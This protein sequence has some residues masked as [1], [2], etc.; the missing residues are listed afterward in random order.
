MRRNASN[1]PA[2]Q[3]TVNRAKPWSVPLREEEPDPQLPNGL[4]HFMNLQSNSIIGQ[5]YDAEQ[6]WGPKNN[7]NNANKRQ[8]VRRKTCCFFLFFL[9]TEK[10]KGTNRSAKNRCAYCIQTVYLANFRKKGRCFMLIFSCSMYVT[11]LQTLKMMFGW[12]H[13]PWGFI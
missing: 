3:A 13:D 8:T 11:F 9:T 2:V 5:I 12:N 1:D 7:Q 4:M 6:G 10:N